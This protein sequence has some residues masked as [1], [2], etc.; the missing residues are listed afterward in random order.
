[1]IKL[2]PFKQSKGYCGPASLKMVLSAYGITKSENYLAKITKSSRTKGCDEDNI[3]KA[4]KIL[5]FKGYVKPNSSIQEVKKLVEKGIPVIVDWFSPEEA[6]H[7]SVVVGFEKNKIILADP[8]F[9]EIK[10]HKIDWFE[11]RWFD[12]PFNKKGPLLKEIIVIHR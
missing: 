10:K 7:Y 12:L 9:G 3:V 2:K 8:H 11:E 5:G 4:S 6:G 1:M